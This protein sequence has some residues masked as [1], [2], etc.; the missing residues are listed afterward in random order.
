[1]DPSVS[2]LG[3]QGLQSLCCCSFPETS[4]LDVAFPQCFC[5]VSAVGDSGSSLNHARQSLG[6]HQSCLQ[7]GDNER[8]TCDVPCFLRP[9]QSSLKRSLVIITHFGKSFRWSRGGQN[10]ARL[11]GSGDLE[12]QST[13]AAR[14]RCDSLALLRT[15]V[16]FCPRAAAS[17]QGKALGRLFLGH[18]SSRAV[19]LA[20]GRAGAAGH[21]DKGS[22]ML[23]PG[24][25]KP[26]TP[27]CRKLPC[28]PTLPSAERLPRVLPAARLTGTRRPAAAVPP[29]FPAVAQPPNGVLLHP[30]LQRWWEQPVVGL[31][32]VMSPQPRQDGLSRGR[33]GGCS[34]ASPQL[35]PLTVNAAFFYARYLQDVVY[36]Q[37]GSWARARSSN[38]AVAFAAGSP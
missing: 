17:A 5:A 4:P 2:G 31:R 28:C 20:P 34:S 32:Q 33:R 7:A 15:S 10:P 24:A 37:E 3:A 14:W 27:R 29:P 19:P 12:D 36:S 18:S 38:A 22:R 25:P 16:P 8:V 21:G 30:V 9:V 26:V 23:V 1:M 6:Q 35:S 13:L 11:L